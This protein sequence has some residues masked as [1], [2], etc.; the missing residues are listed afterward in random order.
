M[1][2]NKDLEI[3]ARKAARRAA[4]GNTGIGGNM[5]PSNNPSGFGI[6]TPSSGGGNG[7]LSVE[8]AKQKSQQTGEVINPSHFN[9]RLEWQEYYDALPQEFKRNYRQG[10]GANEKSRN[11]YLSFGG[12]FADL[13]IENKKEH[14]QA[15][16]RRMS[17][18]NLDKSYSYDWENGV[19][20]NVAT[21]DDANYMKPIP[22]SPDDYA[23][24]A[25]IDRY[26]ATPEGFAKRMQDST[27]GTL[28]NWSSQNL[29]S[30]PN[31][32]KIH[33]GPDGRL[34]AT[35]ESGQT[36]YF[37]EYGNALDASGNKTGINYATGGWGSLAGSPSSPSGPS[38]SPAGPTGIG[39]DWAKDVS[40]R[41]TANYSGWGHTYGPGTSGTGITLPVGVNPP[42]VPPPVPVTT[43]GAAPGFGAAQPSP[44]SRPGAAPVGM[45]T[46]PGVNQGMATRPG[47]NPGLMASPINRSIRQPT[48]NPFSAPGSLIGTQ[49]NPTTRQRKQPMG[50]GMGY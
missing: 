13:G 23:E 31:T 29:A 49:P 6:S 30:D 21:S 36:I 7:R 19:K 33:L 27:R 38:A 9:S 47:G 41:P 8:E 42:P 43:P 20:Y 50:F 25:E 24:K 40:R 12:D 17:M 37:D 35:G 28:R 5:D 46:N 14:G 1:P 3:E 44:T 16:Y 39:G 15:A 45:M 10:R 22:L 2:K 26:G 32:G 4:S 48:T 18:H 34:Q 11:D